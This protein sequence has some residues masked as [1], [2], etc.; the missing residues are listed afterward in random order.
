[1]VNYDMN[2]SKQNADHSYKMGTHQGTDECKKLA[3]MLTPF[4]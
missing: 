2:L 1:M 4:P 3:L